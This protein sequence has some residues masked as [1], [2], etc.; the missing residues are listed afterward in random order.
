[1]TRK[2][3][4]SFI[5]IS[6]FVASLVLFWLPFKNDIKIPTRSP[7]LADS[8]AYGVTAK[9]FDKSG[10]LVSVFKTPRLMHY[11]YHDSTRFESPRITLYQKDAP[12]WRIQAD[13]GS[14][15]D[16]A[17]KISFFENVILQQSQGAN[18]KASKISTS[19]LA[20]FPKK[21]LATSDVFIRLEQPGL[22]IN[23]TGMRAYLN[24]NRVVLLAKARGQYD[25]G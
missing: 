12:P 16:G 11:P 3:L 21:Q 2:L 20:Y 9:R 7:H 1:M 10:M 14:S 5:L 13:R 23:S 15:R 8:I 24:E 18:N 4:P 6:I 25:N 19:Q 22:D 17:S